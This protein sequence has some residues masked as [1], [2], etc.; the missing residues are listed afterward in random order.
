MDV[1]A[2][3]DRQA[4]SAWQHEW[5]L[6]DDTVYLNHGSFGPPPRPVVAARQAWQQQL[7][8]Q[9]MDFFF[10][11]LE[12]AWLEARSKLA[13]F[14]GTAAENLV[15][16]ENATA[17]MNILAANFPLQPTD[18]VVLTNH[19]YGAVSRVWHR[20]C[21]RA[22]ATPPIVTR[23]PD[24]VESADQVVDAIFARVDEHSRLLI[25]SHITSPTAMILP[26]TEICHRARRYGI[27]VCVD[28]PHAP[29]QIPLDIDAIGCDFYTASCHKWLSAPFGS[30]FLAVSPTHHNS[31]AP[32]TLCW[33]RLPPAKPQSWWEEFIWSG[34]RDPSAY[35]T[36]PDAI[37]FVQAVGADAFRKRT[38]ALASYARQRLVDLTGLEPPMPDDCSWYG[39]MAL[40]PLPAGDG[41]SLQQSLWRKY[42]IEVPIVTFEGNR[43]IRV[44]C[45][46]YNTPTH[47]D[48]LVDALT[49][50]GVAG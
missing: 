26:V 6:R 14:V 39:S 43:Y 12:P 18:N 47:I 19:E 7:D 27:A 42:G 25:V 37:E 34:T 31:F 32:S 36:V 11:R 28:G 16:V 46:L 23:L 38:H 44:S 21:R 5:N 30:G 35:L 40:V 41:P 29:A 13:A 33:G 24:R 10:R 48:L 17:G 3:D 15:F 9:P 22:G 50:L 2:L 49:E 45:H 1:P 8:S 4:W 20:A